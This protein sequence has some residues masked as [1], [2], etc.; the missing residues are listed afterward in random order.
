MSRN[1]PRRPGQKDPLQPPEWRWRTL[2]V[3]IALTG[4]M[5]AGWYIAAAGAPSP[6]TGWSFFVLIALLFLFSLGLSRIVNRY[7]TIWIAKRRKRS[8]E[9]RIL[10]DPA[11][12]R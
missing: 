3:W 6:S 2:P 11:S 12:R 10:K 7:T 8:Q 4:G 5:V 9:K 1:R